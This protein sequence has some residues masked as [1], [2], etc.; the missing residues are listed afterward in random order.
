[1]Y[2]SCS[3]SEEL[4]LLELYEKERREEEKRNRKENMNQKYFAFKYFES[5]VVTQ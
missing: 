5:M 1:M 2:A 3:V 4:S